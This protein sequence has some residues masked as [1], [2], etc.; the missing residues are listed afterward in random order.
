MKNNRTVRIAW[1]TQMATFTQRGKKR[2]NNGFIRLN[3][4]TITGQ[5]LDIGGESIFYPKGT[6]LV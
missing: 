2:R 3:G 6:P 5:K 4:V 1:T